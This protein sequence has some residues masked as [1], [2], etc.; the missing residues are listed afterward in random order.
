MPELFTSLFISNESNSI[1]KAREKKGRLSN[2]L[3]NAFLRSDLKRIISAVSGMSRSGN[4]IMIKSTIVISS[5]LLTV[6]KARFKKPTALILLYGGIK[7]AIMI[8]D[9]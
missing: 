5:S 6:P 3:F 1:K 2:R 9:A 7:K 8:S 4:E